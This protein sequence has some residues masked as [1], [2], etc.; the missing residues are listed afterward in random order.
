MKEGLCPFHWKPCIKE[1]CMA[2]SE[3]Q[4]LE[5]LKITNPDGFES[6]VTVLRM[7]EGI[8]RQSALDIIEI[9]NNNER[10]KLVYP[11]QPI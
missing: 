5:E 2:W 8:S 3:K 7:Q 1:Q 4:D 9:R 6:L 10:C 11:E